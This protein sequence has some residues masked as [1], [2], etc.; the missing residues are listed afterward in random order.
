MPK[1]K[2]RLRW[3]KPVE[4]GGVAIRNSSAIELYRGVAKWQTRRTKNPVGV[5]SRVSSSLISSTII[6]GIVGMED[7]ADLE[8]VA[9]VRKSSNLLSPTKFAGVAQR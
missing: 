2:L 4:R 9:L 7:K 3:Y 6:S 5:I 1:K 8:S